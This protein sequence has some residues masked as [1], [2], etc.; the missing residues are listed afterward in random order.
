MDTVRL[1]TWLWAA[2]FFKTRSQA[3]RACELGRIRVNGQAAKPAHVVRVGNRLLVTNESGD[4]GI[5]VLLLSAMRGPAAVAHTLYRETEES[6]LARQ[7]LAEAQKAAR[8]FDILP[9]S[10]PTKRDRRLIMRL[11]GRTDDR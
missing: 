5:D 6:R 1:D 7:K 2:R 10:R 11:R 8:A 9:P 4:F 3:K